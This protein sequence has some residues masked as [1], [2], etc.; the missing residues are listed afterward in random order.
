MA[1][2]DMSLE[3]LDEL[4]SG[5]RLAEYLQMS[6]RIEQNNT[7]ETMYPLAQRNEIDIIRSSLDNNHESALQGVYNPKLEYDDT[8]I[9]ATKDHSLTFFCTTGG[10]VY[11]TETESCFSLELEPQNISTSLFEYSF[12]DKWWKMRV[13]AGKTT[14]LI[15]FD[16]AIGKRRTVQSDVTVTFTMGDESASVTFHVIPERTA[17]DRNKKAKKKAKT[18]GNL[19]QT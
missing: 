16:P 1:N 15:R 7:I 13:P 3:P 19:S 4:F 18:S 2:L 8:N 5:E 10:I 9:T 12:V 14:F 17:Q 6:P 11:I